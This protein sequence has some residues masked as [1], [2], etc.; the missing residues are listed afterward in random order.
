M[1]TPADQFDFIDGMLTAPQRR[2]IA[3]DWCAT[4]SK[5]QRVCWNARR[6]K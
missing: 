6:L 4:N 2:A 1:L 5:T 3:E